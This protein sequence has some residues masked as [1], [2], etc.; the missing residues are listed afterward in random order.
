MITKCACSKHHNI[1]F[2]HQL[3][4]KNDLHR[5]SHVNG[6]EDL[7]DHDEDVYDDSLSDDLSVDSY[8]DSDTED[9]ESLDIVPPM[10]PALLDDSPLLNKALFDQDKTGQKNKIDYKLVRLI[11]KTL[12]NLIQSTASQSYFTSEYREQLHHFLEELEIGEGEEAYPLI[13]LA[14][15]DRVVR[16]Y[17]SL[18]MMPSNQ[19]TSK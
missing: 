13:L 2:L 8:A 3:K 4:P 1:H 12:N 18:L 10:Q 7:H 5:S 19:T 11:L 17:F 16:L 14:R 9:H 6:K 15:K